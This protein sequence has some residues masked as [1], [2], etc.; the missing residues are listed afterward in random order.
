MPALL[1]IGEVR[2]RHVK[3]ADAVSGLRSLAL[4]QRIRRRPTKIRQELSLARRTLFTTPQ[5]CSYP[6]FLYYELLDAGE[7]I[8]S[9]WVTWHSI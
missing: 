5:N 7:I 9:I 6:F 8:F 3:C 4:Q 1:A 2:W